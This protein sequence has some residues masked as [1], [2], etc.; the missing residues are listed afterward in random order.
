MKH[1]IFNPSN[2]CTGFFDDPQPDTVP[3][4][5][6]PAVTWFTALKLQDGQVVQMYP[7]LSRQAQEARFNAD[8]EAADFEREKTLQIPGIK[9][10][11]AEKIRNLDWRLERAR[12]LD[13][14]EGGTARTQE[15]LLQ[16]QAIRAASNA[17]EA[18]VL[19][20]TTMEQLE[21]IDIRYW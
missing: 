18:Q 7:G 19:A 2:E 20:C 10:I 3:Y 1:L 11:A 16:R 6:D 12:E 14:L 4:D 15:I 8:K 9:L 17:L 5:F 21:A 13:E